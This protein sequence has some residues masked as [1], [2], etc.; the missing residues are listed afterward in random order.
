MSV[1]LRLT[2]SYAGFLLV[3]GGALIA[4]LFYVLRFVPDEQIDAGGPFVPSRTDLIEALLPRVWQV[5]LA[6]A[7]VGLIGGWF[8]AGR[9]LRPLARISAVAREVAAGSLDRRVGLGGRPDEFGLLADAFDSMLE[10]LERSFAEQRR[11]AANASHELRTPQAIARSIL[12]AA[13]ADPGSGDPGETLR[14]LDETNRRGTEIVEALLALAALDSSEPLLR[15]PVDIAET[16]SDVVDELRPLA[17]ASGI[18]VVDELG[19]GSFDGH[20]VLVRQLLGNLVLNGVRHNVP[21]SGRVV[22]ATRTAPDGA[23]EVAVVNTGP[24]VPDALLATMTEPF[25]RGAGRTA[26]GAGPRGAGLG[27]ALAARIVQVHD[28]ELRLDARDEGG[29]TVTVR[30]PPPGVWSASARP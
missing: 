21:E 26:G 22:V 8:L 28:G 25:V 13:L 23:V 2:L 14:R 6:L 12:D 17:E 19:E 11:F 3:A 18:V 16:A 30:F 24:V 1:R 15:E 20:P 5:L 4:L 9:I 29:L 7:V 10:R 27:L